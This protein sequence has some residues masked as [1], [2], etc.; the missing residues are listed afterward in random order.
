M[1]YQ[2]DKQ[3]TKSFYKTLHIRHEAHFYVGKNSGTVNKPITWESVAISLSRSLHFY[4][5]YV[6]RQLRYIGEVFSVRLTDTREILLK[7]TGISDFAKTFAVWYLPKFM[8]VR[9]AVPNLNS[10]SLF[11]LL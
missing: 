3:T 5:I 1:F 10:W 9:C 8:I 4:S 2:S 7:P 11:T 6:I